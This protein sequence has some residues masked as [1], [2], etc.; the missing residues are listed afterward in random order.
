MNSRPEIFLVATVLLVPFLYATSSI[1]DVCA[2]AQ[3]PGY[4]SS[5]SCTGS[6]DTGKT[7]CWREKVEGS[8]LG[9]KWCQTCTTKPTPDGKGASTTCTWPKKQASAIEPSG[10]LPGLN[11]DLTQDRIP[12]GGIFKVP[13]TNLTFSQTDNSSTSS[14]NTLAQLQ[15]DLEE[16]EVGGTTGEQDAEEEQDESEESE[17][18]TE[19]E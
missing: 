16:D 8:M 12:G 3:H 17:D 10:N 15:S 4:S 6:D 11:Q 14:N 5:A 13:E 18:S 7:C 9:E 2:E 1:P 19:D